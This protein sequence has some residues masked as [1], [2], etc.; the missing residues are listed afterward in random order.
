[1]ATAIIRY[2]SL[3]A[4]AAA[5]LLVA[6]CATAPDPPE[7]GALHVTPFSASAPGAAIP[8]EWQ[9][10]RLSHF[11]KPSRY[12]LVDND[13]TTVVRG[14]ARGT[15]SGLIQYLDIDPRERPMLTWRWK[16]M[17]LVP[18]AASADDSPA[19][20][21]VS[22]SGDLD[23]LSLTDRIFYDNFR[24]VSGQQLPYAALMYVWGSRT[25]KDGIIPNPLTSRVKIIAADSGPERLRGWQTVTRNVVEDFRRA[26][27][28]EPGTVVSIGIL[29][30]TEHE[31][32]DLEVYYGDLAF[33]RA[34]PCCQ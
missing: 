33:R 1:M 14:T 27:G 29:T 3:A 7:K 5:P 9:S 31:Q 25:A 18:T 10:W 19:R 12:E 22:F 23:K 28:E 20:V 2:N 11:R 16:V 17:D 32:H 24:L 6:A 4:L 34:M 13:G 21:V 30:E 15:A 8:R 26:F